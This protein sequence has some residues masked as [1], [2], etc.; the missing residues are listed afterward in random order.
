ML[1]ATTDHKSHYA[2]QIHYE[3]EWTEEIPTGISWLNLLTAQY[4]KKPILLKVH[5]HDRLYDVLV[6][7]AVHQQRPSKVVMLY[8]KF[9]DLDQ[10]MKYRI[11]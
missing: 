1:A 9:N 2:E 7:V 3:V 6:K 5:I 4:R 8:W 11:R 10:E